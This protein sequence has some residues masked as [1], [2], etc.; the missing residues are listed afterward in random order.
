MGVFGK[1][2]KVSRAVA[3]PGTD[4]TLP[5]SG[6]LLWGGITA[7]SGVAG[8]TGAD[9]K[10]VKGDRWQQVV[11]SM[12]ENFTGNVTSNITQNQTLM[13]TGDRTKQVAGN[14][15]ETV[16]GNRTD[17][18][19]G[20]HTEV[21][22]SARNNTYVSPKVEL[23]SSPR[24]TEEVGIFMKSVET[25]LERG[26]LKM[27]DVQQKIDIS[28]ISTALFLQK[29]DIGMLA[30]K[31]VVADAGTKQLK[32]DIAN[33]FNQVATVCPKIIVT[34]ALVGLLE[35]GVAFKP[36]AMPEPTPIT[37]FD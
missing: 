2:T 12:T 7:A 35:S 14:H 32:T 36:N 37:P 29:L 31:V 22:V 8:T 34:G 9:A 23:H 19:I 25:L 4:D 33:M 10:L 30:G 20:P 24:C 6:A 26:G 27:T 11:G 17:S 15:V 28:G 5:S 18:T 13:V 21:N 1:S 3:D 16:V